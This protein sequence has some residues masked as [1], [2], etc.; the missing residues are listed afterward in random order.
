MVSDVLVY[1]YD[2]KGGT[3][4]NKSIYFIGEHN[5]IKPTLIKVIQKQN[6]IIFRMSTLLIAGGVIIVSQHRANKKLN[7]KIAKLNKKL[8]SKETEKK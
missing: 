1:G 6:L 4:M 7:A 5:D 3:I 8:D 2:Y